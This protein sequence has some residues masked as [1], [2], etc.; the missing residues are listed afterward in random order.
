MTS[1]YQGGN[2]ALNGSYGQPFRFAKSHARI[3]DEEI[4][5]QEAEARA[6]AEKKQHFDKLFSDTRKDR[7]EKIADRISSKTEYYPGQPCEI[8]GYDREVAQVGLPIPRGNFIDQMQRRR[9]LKEQSLDIARRLEGCGI[10]AM[11]GRNLSFVD[12]ITGQAEQLP[13]Y[14]NTNFIPVVQSRN[15]H[16]MMQHVA[17]YCD[18]PKRKDKLRMLVVSGGFIP[19][20]NYRDEHKAHTRR[21][22][23]FASII[24]KRFGLEVAYYN[25]ENTIKRVGV[26]AM[27]NMHSHALL[28]VP[29]RLTKKR[30]SEFTEFTRNFFPKGYVNDSKVMKAKEV[31]KYIF[32]P[33]E[34]EKLTDN[35]FAELYY[36]ISGREK[37][38]P[39]TGEIEIRETA[40]GELVPC[41]EGALKFFHP[42][43]EMK[44]FRASLKKQKRKLIRHYDH[45]KGVNEWRTTERREG[46]ASDKPSSS[47][48]SENIALA[49]TAPL[50]YF[51]PRRSPVI[52]VENYNGNLSELIKS[53]G[54]EASQARIQHI[55]QKREEDDR[56]SSFMKHTTTTTVLADGVENQTKSSRGVPLYHSTLSGQF[57]SMEKLENLENKAQ[58]FLEIT[59]PVETRDHGFGQNQEKRR[60]LRL[61]EFSG[62]N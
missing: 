30:W 34:F 26:E 9:E 4:W 40:D 3:H 17:Y 13:D 10:E 11:Q 20:R 33:S 6:E 61:G 51:R 23:K 19:I 25:V 16:D 57:P 5:E 49:V 44:K 58:E 47:L 60:S 15:V 43:G 32:K 50:P 29:K 2:S 54:L 46:K 37:Y 1:Q 62:R 35:E 56:R 41:K 45:D 18:A 39:E 38:D 52:V 59:R 7:A 55:Y 8:N 14:R 21:M 48:R 31:V 53:N 42:L 27:L 36:Q 28:Y 12:M 24:R 22:S